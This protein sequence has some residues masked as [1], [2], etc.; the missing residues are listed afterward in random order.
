MATTKNGVT[1]PKTDKEFLEFAALF[2]SNH[3]EE[4][5]DSNAYYYKDYVAKLMRTAR[6][7]RRIARSSTDKVVTR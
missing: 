1:A 3:A 5:M 6:R 7:L 4:M 2:I